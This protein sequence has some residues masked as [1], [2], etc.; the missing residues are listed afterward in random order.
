MMTM[1]IITN[2]PRLGVAGL[3]LVAAACAALAVP[4]HAAKR[5]ET[6]LDDR[7]YEI[8]LSSSTPKVYQNRL[9]KLLKKREDQRA[10]KLRAK[11]GR[12]RGRRGIGV[13]ALIEQTPVPALKHLLTGHGGEVRRADRAAVLVPANALSQNLDITVSQP[14]AADEG[15]RLAVAAN[16]GKA[17]ASVPVA[18]GPEGTV[19]LEPV[20]ITLP[21]D[22]ALVASKGLREADLKVHYWNSRQQ[23]WEV[24][25]STVD[26]ALR[27]VSAPT[28]HFSVYQVL[29]PGG[30]GIGVAAADP[31]FGFKAVYT[32]PNPVRGQNTATIRVQPGLADS[33]EVRV[34]DL[35][36]RTVHSSTDF[37][38]LGAY[39]DGNGLGAQF[40]YEHVWDVSGIG[41]GVYTYA[42]VARKAGEKEIR[43][44]GKVGIVK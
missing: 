27:T 3:W 19:F 7:L 34:Y 18:F 36:G 41:S 32:F 11:Q 9:K 16:G 35:S 2:R 42:V 23:R 30:A 13:A 14:D 33:V 10:Q 5:G 12:Q 20:T 24:L 38:S 28:T 25:P 39:D 40:T 8:A 22:S 6:V 29:G 4:A 37:R 44:T 31:S 26:W 43:K 17:S 21:Y 1:G 15:A